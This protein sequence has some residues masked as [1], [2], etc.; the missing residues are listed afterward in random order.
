M[1]FITLRHAPSIPRFLKN[2]IMTGCWIL[3]N[4]FPASIEMIMWIFILCFVNV[5]YH[6]DLFADIEPSLHLWVKS[7]GVRSWCMIFL[8]IAEFGLLTFVE[9]FWKRQL[10]IRMI[11]ELWRVFKMNLEQEWAAFIYL[12][13]RKKRQYFCGNYYHPTLF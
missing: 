4:A 13:R 12:R 5:V 9:D 8:C 6:T 7:H 11:R 3:S 1:T 2:F 10:G